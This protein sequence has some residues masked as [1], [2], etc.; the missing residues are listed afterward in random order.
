MIVDP[1]ADF[2]EE[3]R[4]IIGYK[5]RFKD[6]KVLQINYISKSNKYH[7]KLY[8]QLRQKTFMEEY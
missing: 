6:S 4:Q 5:N 2:K 7:M 3:F 8:K 1:I